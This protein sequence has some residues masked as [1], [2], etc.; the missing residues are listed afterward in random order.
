M[1]LLDQ[2]I[3]GLRSKQIPGE[4]VFKLYDTFGFPVDLT[5]DIARERGVAQSGYR[6]VANCNA[7]A[8]QSV[9]HVHLHMVGGRN[10]NWPPG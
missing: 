4:T 10:L 8:G 1:A 3:A 2:A 5:A 7:H 9:W 6:V